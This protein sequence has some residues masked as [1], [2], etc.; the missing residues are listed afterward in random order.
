MQKNVLNR[1]KR[2]HVLCLYLNQALWFKIPLKCP[3]KASKQVKI[4]LKC[5]EKAPKI[6]SDSISIQNLFAFKRNSTNPGSKFVFFFQVWALCGTFSLVKRKNPPLKIM[7]FNPPLLRP[8][9][10]PQIQPQKVSWT[11]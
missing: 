5:T 11:K 1:A 7:S 3:K 8:P 2:I 4:C 6:A 9:I 10:R